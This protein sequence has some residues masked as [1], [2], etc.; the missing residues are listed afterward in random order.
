M[1]RAQRAAIGWLLL[2][3]TA[4]ATLDAVA[5][6]L[7]R[8]YPVTAAVWFRYI[9]P[10]LLIGAWLISKKGWRALHTAH[11]RIELMR[12]ATLVV[13]T[14]CF[15]TALKH[16]PLLEAA[17]VSFI[18]PTLIVVMSALILRERPEPIHWIAL[19]IGFL[20]VLVTLRPGF[21]HPG[22]GALAALGSAFFYGLYQV[23]TRK[24]A[25][26]ADPTSMLFYAN[27][28]G[29][30]LLSF[31][32]PATVRIPSGWEWPMVASLGVIS[33]LGHW[34]MIRA[35]TLSDARTLAPFMYFQLG[36]STLYGWLVFGTLPDGFT[37]LGMLIIIGSGLIVLVD[38][39]RQGKPE[40]PTAL[41][42]D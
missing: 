10:T 37:L 5:K 25:Q 28:V 34:C 24:V 1:T 40:P 32:V 9:V 31:I 22:V 19:V 11:P 15:W 42:P 36:V 6:L 39:R 33:G 41:E 4:F 18:G 26:D 16:L 14:L 23:L 21:S 17:T 7:T 12:G 38:M 30:F 8:V 3:I 27:A 35:Y 13:S 2:A 20:G 29:A